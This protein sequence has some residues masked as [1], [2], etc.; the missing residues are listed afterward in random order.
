MINDN[1]IIMPYLYYDMW[2]SPELLEG[3]LEGDDNDYIFF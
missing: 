2:Y 1:W 3:E